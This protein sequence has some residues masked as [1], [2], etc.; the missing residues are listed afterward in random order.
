MKPKPD[1]T[2][3]SG[4]HRRPDDAT[5]MAEWL[6]LLRERFPHLDGIS[7]RLLKQDE[8][9]RELCDEYAACTEVVERLKRCGS[10]EPLL[11]EYTALRLR[12][13]AELLSY[14]STH[15]DTSGRP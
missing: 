2:R 12:V 13:E 5:R 1:G 11:R 4:M 9:F 15:R 14:M 8:T 6:K 10:D 7:L 3:S